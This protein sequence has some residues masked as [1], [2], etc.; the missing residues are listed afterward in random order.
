VGNIPQEPETI[1]TS[2]PDDLHAYPVCP[3]GYGGWRY[4]FKSAGMGG[5][6]MH[7]PFGVAA[8]LT[9][10]KAGV[11]VAGDDITH[12]TSYLRSKQFDVVEDQGVWI[13]DQAYGAAC[14]QYWGGYRIYQNCAAFCWAALGAPANHTRLEQT[15]NEEITFGSSY[16]AWWLEGF[17]ARY[18]AIRGDDLG[19]QWASG[20][21]SHALA[22]QSED[23]SWNGEQRTTAYKLWALAP[24]R[25][26]C[27]L[28][29]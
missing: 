4:S 8:L 12:L 9:A 15:A 1:R 18:F 11:S 16:G 2:P 22:S 26:G 29:E 6:C 20:Y 5:D 10:Q 17:K 21:E 27:I 7:Q 3:T 24:G 25:L 14:G 28:C 23:G 19:S 13:G